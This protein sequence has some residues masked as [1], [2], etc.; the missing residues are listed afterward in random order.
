MIFTSLHENPQTLLF[1]NTLLTSFGKKEQQ[2]GQTASLLTTLPSA[3]CVSVQTWRP[4]KHVSS[5][6]QMHH[7]EAASSLLSYFC[8]HTGQN[9]FI[10]TC[11]T[12]A[13]RRQTMSARA[14]T[15]KR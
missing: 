9:T 4:D 1:I 13:R 2:W 7:S 10:K 3:V 12:C 6:D 15:A 8:R 11:G 5:P 14:H